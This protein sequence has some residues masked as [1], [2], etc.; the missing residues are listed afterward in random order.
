[1][2]ICARAHCLH[3]AKNNAPYIFERWC[4]KVLMSAF[5]TLKLPLTPDELDDVLN[6]CNKPQS[7]FK[8]V[9]P[10]SDE[11][12]TDYQNNIFEFSHKSFQ[13][14]LTA[15]QLHHKALEGFTLVKSDNFKSLRR[16]HQG[17]QS[18]LLFYTMLAK[19][20]VPNRAAKTK[21]NLGAY[22]TSNSLVKADEVIHWLLSLENSQQEAL[23]CA[24]ELALYTNAISNIAIERIQDELEGVIAFESGSL[25]TKAD[26]LLKQLFNKYNITN[27]VLMTQS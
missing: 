4:K 14:F 13:D 17:K 1:V 15:K 27:D 11:L 5:D 7:L 20:T 22:S 25:K 8:T 26:L 21:S 12:A 3:H 10:K 6:S 9:N 18:V 19:S 16:W 2:A 24:S 23:F